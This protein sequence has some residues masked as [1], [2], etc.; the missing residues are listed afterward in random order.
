MPCPGAAPAALPALRVAIRMP[1]RASPRHWKGEC[2]LQGRRGLTE[3]KEGIA[4][5]CT[6]PLSPEQ[7]FL[8]LPPAPVEKPRG[9]CMD[10]AR[11]RIAELGTRLRHPKG[12]SRAPW[13]RPLIRRRTP[14]APHAP[15]PLTQNPKA[16]SW[17]SAFP[18]P[19]RPP[20]APKLGTA[21]PPRSTASFASGAAPRRGSR[22]EG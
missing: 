14:P 4:P 3:L 19:A 10:P 9:G 6:P 22:G 7:P 11:S 5:H 1:A 21:K 12:R 2:P 16:F 17:A 20:E 18:G 15:L 8:S 13:R